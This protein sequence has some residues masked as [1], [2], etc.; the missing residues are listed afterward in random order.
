VPDRAFHNHN[1]LHFVITTHCISGL[2]HLQVDRVV[3]QVLERYGRL[4]GVVNCVGSVVARS[5]LATDL[6]ELH[7]TLDVSQWLAYLGWLPVSDWL[8]Q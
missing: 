4:D 5:A 7:H 8:T 1:T 6:E 2:W 3:Q